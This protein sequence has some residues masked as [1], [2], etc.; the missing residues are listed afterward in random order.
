[1]EGTYRR[2]SGPMNENKW[3]DM[4]AI[5]ICQGTKDIAMQP[6]LGKNKPKLQ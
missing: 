6:N 2:S 3:H 4:Y 1:M 5:R